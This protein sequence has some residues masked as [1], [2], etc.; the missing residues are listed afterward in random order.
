MKELRW[1]LQPLDMKTLI[2]LRHAASVSNAGDDWAGGPAS[3]PLSKQGEARAQEL[4]YNWEFP[5]P[6][7]ICCSTYARSMQTAAPFARR[8]GLPLK[9]LETLREFNYWDFQ[10]TPQEY[11]N[12]RA[13]AQGYW[14]RLNPHEKAGGRNAET[15]LECLDRCRRFRDY[16][17]QTPF[18]TCVCVSHGYFMHFFRAVMRDVDLPARDLM[19]HLR[20]TLAGNCYENLQVETYLIG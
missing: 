2:L 20:D 17:E 10:W 4:A 15:F 3:I 19:A 6:D 1:L 5:V 13:L 8:F 18:S 14:T 11:E 16:V 7:L 12:K 9:T